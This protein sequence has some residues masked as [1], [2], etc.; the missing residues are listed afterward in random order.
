MVIAL[1]NLAFRGEPV[2]AFVA[3]FEPA[4][5][6]KQ[7]RETQPFGDHKR[8]NPVREKRPPV[9]PLRLRVEK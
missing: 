1:A 2:F 4:T 3:W 8:R 6:G 9:G 5:F 7:V